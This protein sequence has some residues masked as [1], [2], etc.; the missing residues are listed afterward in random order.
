MRRQTSPTRSPA[1]LSSGTKTPATV[2]ASST[3]IVLMPSYNA[4]PRLSDVVAD[5]VRCWT[6]VIAVIDGSSDGSERPVLEMS[7]GTDALTVV[8][9]ERNQGKGGAVIEGLKEAAKRGFTHALV[10]DADGQHPAGS[11]AEFME[12]SRLHPEAMVLGK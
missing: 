9:L 5:V 10:M 4:G 12:A 8:V 3:H 1:L 11:I 7:R 6:P 2:N